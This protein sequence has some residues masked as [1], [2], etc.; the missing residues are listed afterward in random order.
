M[1]IAL[2]LTVGGCSDLYWA[3]FGPSEDELAQ[4]CGVSKTELTRVRS[5][6]KKGRPYGGRELGNCSL[7]KD[8][9]GYV[10]VVSLEEPPAAKR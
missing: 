8:D 5:E 2:A 6:V 9:S 7:I 3:L 4:Q 1:L 10:A